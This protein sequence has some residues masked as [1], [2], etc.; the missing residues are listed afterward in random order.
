LRW[1]LEFFCWLAA[2]WESCI[3]PSL[4]AFCFQCGSSSAGI[5][6]TFLPALLRHDG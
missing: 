6:S 5:R 4:Q 3:S 1:P 2:C